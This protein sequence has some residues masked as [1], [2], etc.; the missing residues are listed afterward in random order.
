MVP[1]LGT[2]LLLMGGSKAWINRTILSNK[3]A[4]W[5]GLIS[6]PLYLWHWPLLSFVRIVE[7]EVPSLNIRIVAVVLSILLAW[8]TYKLIERPIRFGKHGSLTV[9]TLSGLAIVIGVTGFVV[10]KT[11]FSQSHTYEKLAIKRKGFEHAFGYSLAWYRGK[12]DWLFLGNASDNTVAK[13]KLAVVPA[14]SEIE[15]TKEIFS[16]IATT[17]AKFNTKVVLIVSPN[18]AS[19]Y[20]E[21]LPDELVPSPKKYSSF[22]TDKLRDVPNLTIYNPT[23][24]FLRLKETEGILY[25]MTNTHW[26]NKGA[27]LAYLGFSKLLG[28]PVPEVEFQR[29]ST[30][31]GDLVDI[32]KFKDF[33]L[34]AEDN[35]DVIWKNLPVLVEKEIPDEQKTSFGSPAIVTNQNPLSNMTIWVVGDSFTNSLKQYFNATFK[36]VRYVGHWSEKLKGLAADLANADKK[37]D[38]IIVVKVERT[39]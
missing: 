29:G 4:V 14:N 12:G 24:D 11:D 18:K 22:F 2:L 16:E 15:A 33:P 6:F 25:G 32:A 9:A 3:I 38:M 17:A 39:F 27:F 13:L 7:S 34:H 23:D 10:N 5:F 26:N 1:V 19:I 30:A 20:S 21:Y 31:R 8:L 35:W 28:L 36:E 37:P